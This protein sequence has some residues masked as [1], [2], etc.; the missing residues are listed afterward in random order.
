MI[1]VSPL[2]AGFVIDAGD[3]SPVGLGIMLGSDAGAG[4]S[5]AIAAAVLS[6]SK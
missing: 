6:D 1:T 4:R 2:S 3:G 5:L